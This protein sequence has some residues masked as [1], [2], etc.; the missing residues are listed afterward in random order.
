MMASCQLKS[1]NELLMPGSDEIS[2]LIRKSNIIYDSLSFQSGIPLVPPYIANGVVGGSFDHMGF[3]H[4]P[5]KGTPNGRTVFGYIG[6]YYMHKPTTRQAQLPLAWIT[7]EF[8]DGFP[9]VNMMD[10]RD[11]RQELDIY[12]GVLTTSYNLFGSTQITAFAHQTI[13]NLFIMKVDRQSDEPGRKM[14]ITINCET[15]K[16]QQSNIDW[17]PLPVKLSLEV[18]GNRANVVFSTNMVDTRWSVVADNGNEITLSDNNLHIHLNDGENIL[19]FIIHR[20]DTDNEHLTTLPYHQLLALHTGEWEENWERSWIDFPE[21]RAHHIWNRANYYNLSN[22]PVTPEKALIPTGMNTNIWGF[23]FPQDVYYVAENLTRTGHFER[24]EKSMQY[25]LDILPE[26]K[27]YSQRIMGIDGSYYPWTPPFAMWDEYEKD[28]VV[29]TDSY[30]IHNPAYVAAMV[31]HYYQRTGDKEFLKK[32]FPIMEEVWRFYSQ[33][34]HKSDRGTYDVFHDA[35]TSQDERF[36]QIDAKNYLDASLSA[37]YT[38]R[39]YLLAAEI[40]D[41]ADPHLVEKAREI[42]KAGLE[43]DALLNQYGYYNTF[44][45]DDRAKNSQKHP[46][47]LNAITFVPMADHGLAQPSVTAW[48]NRYDLTHQARKPISEGWTYAAFAL[49]SSRMGSPEG[50]NSDLSAIQYCAHA[51]PRWIQFY[52]YTFWERWTL[53]TA[54]YFVTH[55]LYQQALSDAIVQDWQGFV[56]IFSSILPQWA[57]QRFSFKGLYTLHGVSVDGVWD[58]GHFRIVLNPNG[59]SELPLRIS[60]GTRKIKVSGAVNDPETIEPGEKVVVVFDGNNPVIIR[61]D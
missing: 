49:S 42:K 48:K 41:N 36:R 51:D 21:D 39:N 53:S 6:H 17:P 58:N 3:Q 2:A 57:D 19:R 55:G 52:E 40:L 24:Y 16:T 56:D 44:E 5:N 45:G 43:R 33:V 12:T 61:N 23:T 13:P 11:Y 29:G 25:W 34:L 54:Y 26:V 30:Q 59:A 28:G 31:W 46:V 9:F 14:V 20:D 50:L 32:Y 27:R 8:A 4:T 22:F 7:A 10:T 60:R 47:Q 35:A 37:E 1:G 15:H 18:N 38:L